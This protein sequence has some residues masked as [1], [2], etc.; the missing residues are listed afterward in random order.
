MSYGR[1]EGNLILSISTQRKRLVRQE[2]SNLPEADVHSRVAGALDLCIQPKRI[3][4][5]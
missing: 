3:T 1:S 2:Q 4:K 5:P